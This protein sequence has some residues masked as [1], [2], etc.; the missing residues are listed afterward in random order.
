MLH[1]PRFCDV[2]V[3]GRTQVCWAVVWRLVGIASAIKQ[4][5]EPR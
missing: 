5:T 2:T 4:L 1:S 3:M